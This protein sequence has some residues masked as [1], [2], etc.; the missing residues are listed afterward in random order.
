MSQSTEEYASYRKITF[1]LTLEEGI[2]R[3]PN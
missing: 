3:V 1:A 2:N